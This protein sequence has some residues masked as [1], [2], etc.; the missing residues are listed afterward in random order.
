MSRIFSSGT[1]VAVESGTVVA[2]RRIFMAVGDKI[3]LDYAMEVGGD[4]DILAPEHNWNR[5]DY[6]ITTKVKPDRRRDRR[7]LLCS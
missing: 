6:A 2:G 5:G 4:Y 1:Y 7:L 3:V